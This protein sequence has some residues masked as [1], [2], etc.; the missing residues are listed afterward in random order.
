MSDDPNLGLDLTVDP[1]TGLTKF[2]LTPEEVQAN[3]VARARLRAKKAKEADYSGGWW[4]DIGAWYEQ[5]T[6][7]PEGDN[8]FGTRFIGTKPSKADYQG[9]S[10]IGTDFDAPKMFTEEEVV[11]R[12]DKKVQEYAETQVAFGNEGI[13][14]WRPVKGFAPIVGNQPPDISTVE[15]LE[16]GL[17]R[18]LPNGVKELDPNKFQQARGR[19][20][21]YYKGS[22]LTDEFG[23]LARRKYDAE[24]A[25]GIDARNEL[26]FLNRA[27]GQTLALLK[28][29]KRT[30]FYGGSE[31]TNI[32][33]NN[34]G[35]GPEDE[36]AMARFLS[37][38][39]QKFQTWQ[40]VA[41][42]LAQMSTVGSTGG[43]RFKPDSEAE[44]IAYASEIS[45]ALTGEKLSKAKLKQALESTI[46][47]Q[48]SAF[49]SG[50]DIPRSATILEQQIPKSNPSQ[51]ASYGLGNAIKLA[52]EAL[53]A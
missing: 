8:I 42:Q 29:L 46:A 33:L 15:N 36:V 22:G 24:D 50:T 51:A 9:L 43:P 10:K 14:Q 17:I 38:S 52:F 16:P 34:Q 13:Y 47:T 48:R 19:G 21:A 28:E 1:E 5:N 4:S 39:N 18:V 45:L 23:R 26:M 6:Y 27:Q 20:P 3:I 30:G 53:G 7:T 25:Q 11:A 12:E 49:A 44:M 40:A 2:G 31:I 41:P 37:F 35:F 32:A